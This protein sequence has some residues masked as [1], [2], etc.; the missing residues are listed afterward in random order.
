MPRPQPRR[1]LRSTAALVGLGGALGLGCHHNRLP[2]KPDGAAVVVAAEEPAA[3]IGFTMAD[4]IEPN[5]LLANAPPQ[6]PPAE[7]GAG[8]GGPQEPAPG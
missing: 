4:E 7:T 6:S 3:E 1:S 5:D 8:E 2:P